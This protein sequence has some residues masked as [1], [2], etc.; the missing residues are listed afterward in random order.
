MINT[1]CL[2]ELMPPC[3]SRKQKA[4]IKSYTNSKEPLGEMIQR[5]IGL[6]R[7]SYCMSDSTHAVTAPDFVSRSETLMACGMWHVT[8]DFNDEKCSG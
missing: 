5:M 4:E 8:I 2:I 7:G 6:I 1:A 3:I